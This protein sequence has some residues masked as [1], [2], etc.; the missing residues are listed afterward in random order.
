[1]LGEASISVDPAVRPFADQACMHVVLDN[2]SGDG[3][4]ALNSINV[5]CLFLAPGLDAHSR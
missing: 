5:A 2:D 1:M 4:A 3:P